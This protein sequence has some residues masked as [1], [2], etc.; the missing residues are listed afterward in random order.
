MLAALDKQ[1]SLKSPT[2]PILVLFRQNQLFG[3][4]NLCEDNL[5]DSIAENGSFS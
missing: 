4:A 5:A 2:G 1:H 3:Y